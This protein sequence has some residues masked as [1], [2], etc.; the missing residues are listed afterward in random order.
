MT[1]SMTESALT[2]KEQQ[3]A[4]L[5][6]RINEM[7]DESAEC[8]LCSEDKHSVRTTVRHLNDKHD[9][10]LRR[11]ETC[12]ECGENFEPTCSSN[13]NKYCS[14]KCFGKASGKGSGT[15]E[16]KN[17]DSTEEYSVAVYDALGREPQY[18]SHDCAKDGQHNPQW[19]EDRVR[20]LR[21]TPEYR[22]WLKSVHESVDCCEHCKTP[23]DEAQLHA[24]HIFPLSEWPDLAYEEWNGIRLCK[25]CHV[26]EHSDDDRL[27]ALLGAEVDD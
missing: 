11:Q 14:E 18:C 2:I 7:T 20:D 16:C 12:Q 13:P 23:E 1:E 27:V 3:A 26:E 21:Q 19:D 24:H 10:S 17:C 8:P 22:D 5:Q 15:F 9:F 4:M 6:N 25:S